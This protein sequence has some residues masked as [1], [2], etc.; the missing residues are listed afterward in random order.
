MSVYSEY[1]DYESD[2][3]ETCSDQGT[4]KLPNDVSGIVSSWF[5]GTITRVNGDDTYEVLRTDGTILKST[6]GNCIRRIVKRFEVDDPIEAMYRKNRVWYSGYVSATNPDGTY[7]I[8]YD[9][10]DYEKSLP[11]ELVRQQGACKF[12]IG[13]QVEAMYRKNHQWYPGYI[14]AVNADGSYD[15]VYDDGDYEKNVPSE[16]ARK[17]QLT[18]AFMK[19]DVVEVLISDTSHVNNSVVA[20]A[21]EATIDRFNIS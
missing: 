16:F 12:Q 11:S 5:Q 10:G 1:H 2:F 13:D 14:S 7:D 21:D 18:I 4:S 3:D 6:A 8:V 15:V 17:V 19:G 9:D 20:D